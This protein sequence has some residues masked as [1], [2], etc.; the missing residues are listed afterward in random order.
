M[1]SNPTL[2][3]ISDWQYYA[4]YLP[5]AFAFGAVV[6]SFL[7]VV[8]LR[9]PAGE[10]LIRPRSHCPKCNRYLKW[11]ENLPVIGWIMLK[12]RCRGCKKPISIQYP[13]IEAI[14]GLGFTV[15]FFLCY[16][17]RPDA[18]YIGHLVPNYWTVLSVDE[19]WPLFILYLVLLSA[20]LA[21]T[22]IDARTFMLP[23]EVTWFVTTLAIIVHTTMPIWPFKIKIHYPL[24]HTELAYWTIP[25]VSPGMLFAGIGGM[26]GIFISL[27][28]RHTNNIRHSYLDYWHYLP[29]EQ[30]N[31]DE[32]SSVNTPNNNPETDVSI[33]YPDSRK[34]LEWELDFL[35]PVIIC[36][37][38][39]WM[40]GSSINF[41]YLPLWASSLGGCLIGYLVG[42]GIIWT[43]RILGTVAFG[44][45]AMGLGDVHLLGCIGAVLGWIDPI[46]IFFLAPFLAIIGMALGSLIGRFVKGFRHVLP[47]GPWLALATVLVMLGDKWIEPWLAIFLNGDINLP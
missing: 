43:I 41:T 12:G 30:N 3:M 7:N 16:M 33:A 28:L 1:F 21:M 40:I 17:V 13:L 2:Y 35:A 15:M 47:Y 4:I 34:E 8:I 11:H 18:P 22:V 31:E 42:A 19:T 39:G 37:I 24:A 46:L 44:K 38:V 45:E 27:I 36:M 25:L 23:I 5:F 26:L 6:G 29:Q 20:L 32:N 9:W 14:C 10:N